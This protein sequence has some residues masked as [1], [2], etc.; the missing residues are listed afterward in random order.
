MSTLT[1]AA[2]P[3]TSSRSRWLWMLMAAI[4]LGQ[5]FAFWLLCSHQV[6][7]AEARHN[8]TIVQQMAL[9]DCL[10]YIPGSTIASCTIR[11]DPGAQARHAAGQ[12]AAT[13]AVPVSFTY[14]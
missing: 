9:T 2:V 3:A 14:R 8:E 6:R 12:A 4:A 1:T 10:Q 11:L 5:L 13:G 7:K